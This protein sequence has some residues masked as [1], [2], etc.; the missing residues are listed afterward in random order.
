[1]SYAS[2]PL[3]FRNLYLIIFF[4]FPTQ[5]FVLGNFQVSVQ[6]PIMT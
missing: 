3:F 2:I 1:M 5:I 6:G 4:N